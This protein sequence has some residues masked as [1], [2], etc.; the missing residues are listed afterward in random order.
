MSWFKF[1]SLSV[2]VHCVTSSLN[3]SQFKSKSKLLSLKS[4]CDCSG[5]SV[6]SVTSVT[7]VTSVASVA[8]VASVTSVIVIV[9]SAV[10]SEVAEIKSLWLTQWQGHL[11]SC[12][13]QLKT[14][15]KM[16]RSYQE[17]SLPTGLRSWQLN[18]GFLFWRASTTRWEAPWPWRDSCPP[19]EWI[20]FWMNN[21]DFVLNWI[22]NWIIFWPDS[23]KKWIFKTDRPGLGTGLW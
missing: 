20:S 6:I 12:P 17:E 11:L 4:L 3:C 9:S 7:S 18:A 14:R 1:R 23:M 10:L 2:I 13:G 21:P 5:P 22:L 8:S 16:L 19:I 15:K